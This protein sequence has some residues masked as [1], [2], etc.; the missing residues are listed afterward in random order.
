[1]LKSQFNAMFSCNSQKEVTSFEVV[2]VFIALLASLRDKRWRRTQMWRR[3]NLLKA[4]FPQYMRLRK[5]IAFTKHSCRV[6]GISAM[7]APGRLHI[8][9]PHKTDFELS[10]V[11]ALRVYE[12]QLY[13]IAKLLETHTEWMHLVIKIINIIILIFLSKFRRYVP[14]FCN[15]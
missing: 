7:F 5:P 1:M 3:C 15:E 8:L 11:S 14:Y 12:S 10:S 2:W 9:T 13:I 6:H 4:K